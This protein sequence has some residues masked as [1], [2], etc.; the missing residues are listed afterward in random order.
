MGK[1][2]R[3]AAKSET[4]KS[5]NGK[6]KGS[7]RALSGVKKAA[8]VR[9]DVA[10]LQQ[11][12]AKLAAV[13]AAAK[14]TAHA[15]VELALGRAV[16]LAHG[17]GGSSSH[18]SMKAWRALLALS[19]DEVIPVE[20]ARPHHDIAAL[21]ASYA[22]AVAAAAAAGHTRLLLAGV[23][24]GARAALHM[25]T[26]TPSDDGT[27]IHPLPAELARCMRKRACTPTTRTHARMR[28]RA[29][30]DA[31]LP[32]PHVHDHTCV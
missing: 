31:L 15:R 17:A 8:D 9:R 20:F 27:A 2:R 28:E 1:L 19:C 25:L 13:K 7:K 12:K 26:G 18:S 24:L 5:S 10:V 21:A 6:A 3:G 11:L 4:S 29:R 14:P 23:G 32:P 22:N 16:L 30:A